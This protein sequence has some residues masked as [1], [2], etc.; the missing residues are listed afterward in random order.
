M[1]G[2]REIKAQ[3]KSNWRLLLV[4]HGAA[5]YADSLQ[6]LAADLEIEDRVYFAGSRTDIASLLAGADIG[7]LPSHQEGF[8]NALLEYMMA[9]LPVVATATGGNLD[10]VEEGRTGFL[11]SVGARERL[12][13]SLSL[14]VENADIRVRLAKPVE[15]RSRRSSASTAA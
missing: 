9:A 13:R 1:H 2:A 12:G 10:A 15:L 5:D 11:V 3:G 4:G 14:L 6:K 8:S 7:V